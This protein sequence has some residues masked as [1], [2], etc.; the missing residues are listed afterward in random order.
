M[1]LFH[2]VV[3]KIHVWGGLGSQLHAVALYKDLLNRFP[4]KAFML[5]F[6]TGGVT[7]RSVEVSSLFPELIFSIQDDFVSQIMGEVP[8]LE[9]RAKRILRSLFINI[10]QSLGLFSTCNTDQDFST[11][12][13]RVRAIR[14]HYSYRAISIAT[15]YD[16]KQKLELNLDRSALPDPNSIAIHY[17]LGDLLLLEEKNPLEVNRVAQEISYVLEKFTFSKILVYSDSPK[18]ALTALQPHIHDLEIEVKDCSATQLLGETH[19]PLYFIGTSSKIS[20]WSILLREISSADGRSS[21]PEGNRINLI[22]T[23][24]YM[25]SY[26]NLREY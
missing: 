25:E 7:R 8:D 3:C 23:L 15:I 26:S 6:H 22:R 21:I 11:L 18:L 4:G 10:L 19:L 9:D 2:P 5:V 24:G 14:G 1:S 20:F 13:R 12:K 16:I 17:R